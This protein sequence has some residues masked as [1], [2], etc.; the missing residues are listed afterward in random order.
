MDQNDYI[1]FMR[2]NRKS[3]KTVSRHIRCLKVFETYLSEEKQG[4]PLEEADPS[5]VRDFALW[6]D[7]EL[8]GVT[9]YISAIKTFA[10]YLSYHELEMTEN[11]LLGERYA[12]RFLLKDFE[13]V[14]PEPVRKLASRGIQTATQMIAAGQTKEKRRELSE[15]LGVPME[16]VLELVKLSDLSRIPGL[17]SVRARLYYEAGLDTVEKIARWEPGE[18]R[19]MLRGFI[20]RT[21]FPG[22]APLLKEAES[23]VA[24]AGHLPGIVEY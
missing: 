21:G 11:E 15:D 3:E 1:S 4:K 6:G 14:A 16:S 5:D 24:T 18:M 12:A 2:K 8:K 17:K 9:L 7:T 20:E 22:V 23:T 10:E 13:G 19:S